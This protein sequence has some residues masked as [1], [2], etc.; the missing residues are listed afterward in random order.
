MTHEELNDEFVRVKRVIDSFVIEEPRLFSRKTFLVGKFE[1]D[2]DC[3]LLHVIVESPAAAMELVSK[4]EETVN[5]NSKLSIG[6]YGLENEL[7]VRY[8]R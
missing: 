5:P 6:T 1:I 2:K 4:F 3:D 7:L 8:T